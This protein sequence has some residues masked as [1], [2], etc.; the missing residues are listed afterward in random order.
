MSKVPFASL[1]VQRRREVRSFGGGREE[2]KSYA[3]HRAEGCVNIGS[4]DV[5]ISSTTQYSYIW[6]DT[7]VLS[8]VSLEHFRSIAMFINHLASYEGVTIITI[9]YGHKNENY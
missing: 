4:V 8:S 9:D 3:A 1:L 2:Q 6:K 5:S 7:F